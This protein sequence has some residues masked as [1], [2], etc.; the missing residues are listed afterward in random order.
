MS[1]RG[2]SINSKKQVVEY[3]NQP[4]RKKT[5]IVNNLIREKETFEERERAT[6]NKNR[7]SSLQSQVT[8]SCL[9]KIL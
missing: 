9:F 2:K 4:A 8:G 7:I 1:K 3:G 6:L 5:E